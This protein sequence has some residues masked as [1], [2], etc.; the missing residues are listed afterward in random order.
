M[1]MSNSGKGLAGLARL[2][3]KPVIMKWNTCCKN[4]LEV[5]YMKIKRFEELECWK[6]ARKLTKT[7]Y[8]YVKRPDFAK[9]FRLSSQI[10]GASISIMN[11]TC[12]VK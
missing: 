5:I 6:E 7:I 12:P 10:S 8:T 11:N 4:S 9:D 1:G 3:V 2:P